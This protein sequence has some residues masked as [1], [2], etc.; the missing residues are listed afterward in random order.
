MRD[1]IRF[2]YPVYSV[3]VNYNLTVE[4][5]VTVGSYDYANGNITSEHF[6]VQ[7][8]GKQEK[9]IILFH[10]DR[11]IS[12]EEAIQEMDEVGYRPAEPEE[13]LALGAGHPDLQR[14]FTI[15][16]LGSPWQYPVDGDRCAI[17]LWGR[18]SGGRGLGLDGFEGDW[19]RVYR[20]ATVCK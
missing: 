8:Q 16:G 2:V 14:E 12:S 15:V 4:K 11:L 5:M 3:T 10:F 18:G 7:G 1:F 17:C 9:E 13:I 6:L 20:F 19:D